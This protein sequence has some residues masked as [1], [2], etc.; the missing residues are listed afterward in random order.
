M[1]P[2]EAE[3]RPNPLYPTSLI[4]R[5]FQPYL[6]HVGERWRMCLGAS[7]QLRYT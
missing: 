7:R 6:L 5:W 4:V 2:T 3:L 1:R